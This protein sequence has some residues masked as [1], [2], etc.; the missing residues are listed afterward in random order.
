MKSTLLFDECLTTDI[1]NIQKS[2]SEILKKLVNYTNEDTIFEIKVVLNEILNNAIIHG[3]DKNADK[4]IYI[5]SGV[6]CDNFWVIVK[7][8]GKGF[9]YCFCK[10]KSHSKFSDCGRGLTIINRLCDTV[11]VNNEGNKFVVVKKI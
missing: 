3:N 8:E 6:C 2:V 5:K 9:D 11:K 4:N 10:E 7:D 1:N